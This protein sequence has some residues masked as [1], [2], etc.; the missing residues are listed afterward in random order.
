[1]QQTLIEID[2]KPIISEKRK[3]Y[4]KQYYLTYSKQ[5]YAKNKEKIKK[6]ANKYCV[7]H[8]EESKWDRLKQSAKRRKI[9]FEL[10]KTDFVEW[11]K[12]QDLTCCF[13]K[14]ELIY[15]S[16]LLTK[17]ERNNK[18]RFLS[19]DRINNEIGYR[20]DNIQLCCYLCNVIKNS[21]F[22]NEEMKE[23]GLKAKELI[24]RRE[25]R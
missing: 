11:F 15:N 21:F 13:C 6:I 2:Y 10:N 5:Y 7:T 4:A 18:N 20:F 12:K 3:E 25:I 17:E 9:S 14:R 1:M 24:D 23:M 19:I 22:S 16:N 8:K